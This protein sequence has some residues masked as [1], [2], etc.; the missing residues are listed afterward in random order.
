GKKPW[1]SGCLVFIFMLPFSL[2]LLVTYAYAL[3]QILAS[4]FIY[5]FGR[6]CH[7]QPSFVRLISS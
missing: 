5:C 4:F 7:G 6:F 1:I 2:L 3:C